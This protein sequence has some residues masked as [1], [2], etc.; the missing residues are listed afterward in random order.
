MNSALKG[1]PLVALV[2]VTLAGCAK[3]GYYHDRN[4]DY[5]G[6]KVAAPL[7]LPETRD[8]SRYRDIMPVPEAAGQFYA[9]ESEFEAP[10]PQTMAS[11]SAVNAGQVALRESAAGSWLVVGAPPAAVWP[12]LERFSQMRGLQVTNKDASRGVISTADADIELRQGLRQG[13]SEIRCETAGQT[14]T[15]CLT[16]LQSH[17][18]ARSASASIASMSAQQAPGAQS[19]ELQK[20]GN[21]WVMIMPFAID[22]AW[23]EL[24]FQL[25]NNFDMQGRRELVSAD[26]TSKSFVI[27]YVTESERTRGFVDS[28][29]SLSL[30]ESTHR[31]NLTLTPQGSVTVMQVSSAEDE[32]LS[33]DD[34]RE[35]LDFVSGLLR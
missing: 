29:T 17:L 30:W 13:S 9:R 8:T 27:D 11:S 32:T 3:D 15:L 22:R 28:L 10:L 33:A 24:N 6:A 35:L 18:E 14:N 2:A 31:L 20:R 26:E 4:E 1:L 23:A 21:D 5:A 25:S 7:K 19:M 16:E 34:Q 12:E